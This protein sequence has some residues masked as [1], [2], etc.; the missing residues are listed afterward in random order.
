MTEGWAPIL[1]EPPKKRGRPRKRALMPRVG[2]APEPGWQ[3]KE[4]YHRKPKS[5]A[6]EVIRWIEGACFVPEGANVGQPLRLLQWQRDWITE[7]YDNPHTTR[8]AILSL[9]RKNGKTTLVACLLL[10]HLCGPEGH[11]RP[12]S[13]I[14]SAAQSRDQAALVFSLAAKM[15]RLNP[16]LREGVL[17]HESTKSLS[18]PDLGTRY[19]ALAAEAT[20][21][22]GLSPA[23]V[24]HDELGQ[25][26][27]RKQIKPLQN[28]GFQPAA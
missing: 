11:K 21:A 10:V 12:N 23:L 4:R 13:Q 24:V 6:G 20:T 18:C 1:P 8:R 28:M 15:V 17:I 7:I 9:G 5:R 2:N 25:I 14:F 26:C 19:R 3:R 16:I 27:P 22:Y